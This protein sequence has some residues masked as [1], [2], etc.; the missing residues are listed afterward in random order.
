M[1]LLC[2]V[3]GGPSPSPSAELQPSF[4]LN[5]E[6]LL[7]S[8]G[9]I[10]LPDATAASSSS[11]LQ[12]HTVTQAGFQ[13]LLADTYSQ[14]WQL[15]REYIARAERQS[16]AELSTV[17]GFLLQLGF[18]G[19]RPL[20]CSELGPEERNIAAHMVQL[21]VLAAFRANREIWLQPTWLAV[22]MASG[23]TSTTPTSSD[24]FAVVETNSR[25]YAYTA[26]PV[27]QAILRLF[28]RC[29]VLLPNLFVGTITRE[30]AISA[31]E[32]GVSAEQIIGYLRQHAHSRVASRVPIVPG[33][34]SDQ[35][36]LW[37]QELLRVKDS[38]GVFYKN[39]EAVELY[40]QVVAY[41]EELGVVLVKDDARREFVA[42]AEA[43]TKL[44]EKIKEIKTKLGI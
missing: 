4:P 19:N 35:I 3:G 17:L 38:S 36:R 23:S 26:S 13:F 10:A 9:L 27:R 15:L 37:Q 20:R 12:R 29:D 16:S 21:G 32:S 18:Q 31:L 11:S 25:V 1:L 42:V 40:R 44:R 28:V 8:A 14:L 22:L 43:H 30:S 33:V 5:L 24:G 41:G 39:F 2:A 7:L 34:V 6:E